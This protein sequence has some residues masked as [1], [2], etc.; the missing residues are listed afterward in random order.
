MIEDRIT[1]PELLIQADKIGDEPDPKVWVSADGIKF[2]LRRVSMLAVKEVTEGIKDPV[3]PKF[4]NEQKEREEENPMDPEYL[5]EL[6][7]TTYKRSMASIDLVCMLGSTISHLP[8]GISS[9][10]EDDWVEALVEAGMKP[11]P[12]AKRPR[13]AYWLKFYALSESELTDLFMA[14]ARLSGSTIEAEVKRAMDS[15]FRNDEE[16][17]TT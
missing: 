1:T 7:R 4:F 13:Y 6:E 10:D 3:V 15:S 11:P 16:R 9:P 17:A 12:E 5:A 2:A 14:I 8:D